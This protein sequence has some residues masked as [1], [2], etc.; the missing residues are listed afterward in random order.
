M[1]GITA[2]NA[3]KYFE[4]AGQVVREREGETKILGDAYDDTNPLVTSTIIAANLPF[5][6]D[7]FQKSSLCALA[8]GNKISYMHGSH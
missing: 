8:S 7:Y 6:L 5:T 4:K 3:K 2:D 1:L